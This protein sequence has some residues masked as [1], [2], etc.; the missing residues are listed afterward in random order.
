MTIGDA[1]RC[2]NCHWFDKD[3]FDTGDCHRNPPIPDKT[4]L[5][6]SVTARKFP[7]VSEYDWCG[8]YSVKIEMKEP[9]QLAGL[10]TEGKK[11]RQIQTG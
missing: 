7:R 10:S 6:S 2:V 3:G 1:F 4:K 11:G 5:R 9:A 8:Q